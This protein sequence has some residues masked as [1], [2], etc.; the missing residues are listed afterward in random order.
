MIHLHWWS[1]YS[2]L[3]ALWT[4]KQIIEKVEKL[5]QNAIAITDYNAWYGLLEFYEK[6]EKIKPIL[7]VDINFSYDGKN[8]MNIVLLAKN[9]EWYKNLIKLIS[10][11]NT[12]N[13]KTIPYI[14]FDNLKEYSKGL[15]WLSWWKWEIEKLILWNEKDE[16]ILEKIQEYENLFEWEFY[17]EFL[18]YEYNLFSDR[19]KIEWKFEKFLD[20]GKKWVVSSNYKYLNK[21]DKDTYDVLLCV[22]NNWKYGEENRPKVI[23]EHHIMSEKEVLDILSK[24]WLDSS[25]QK[26]LIENT[27]KIADSIDCKVPLHQLL[28]PKYVVPEKYQNLYNKIQ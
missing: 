3:S 23:W 27:D 1:H 21:E 24:N 8:I 7:W 2:M 19:K 18:T 6:S 22:K 15:I 5:W 4:P 14:T 13:F 11:A 20:K 10:I 26:I 28:F 9:Y 16:L 17:L 25:L 12:E